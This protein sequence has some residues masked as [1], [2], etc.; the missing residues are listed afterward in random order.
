MQRTTTVA[1]NK[2]VTTTLNRTLVNSQLLA[3]LLHATLKLGLNLLCCNSVARDLD[4]E[5]RLGSERDRLASLDLRR[6]LRTP[7]VVLRDLNV[8]IPALD[9]AIG[10]DI[11]GSSKEGVEFGGNVL[12]TQVDGGGALVD[13]GLD[14]A[15]GHLGSKRIAL[16]VDVD[17]GILLFASLG[18]GD[19]DT[20]AG[21]LADLL[22]LGSLTTDDVGADGGRDGDIDGLLLFVSVKLEVRWLRLPWNQLHQQSP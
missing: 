3:K 14:L 18:L 22:D 11:V 4:W 15:T 17:N 2:L 20:G 10:M 6:S 5:V 7:S 16:D 19:L 1:N 8:H 13:N 21:A 9:K 12:E